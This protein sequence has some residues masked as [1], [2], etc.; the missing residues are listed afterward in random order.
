MLEVFSYLQGWTFLLV[1]RMLLRQT[2]RYP[3]IDKYMRRTLIY[4]LTNMVFTLK[5]V[6]RIRRVIECLIA[7]S[8]HYAFLMKQIYNCVIVKERAIR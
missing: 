8:C 3:I 5:Q 2:Y 7:Y 1:Q 6:E 4:L